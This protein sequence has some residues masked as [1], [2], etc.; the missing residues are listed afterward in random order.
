MA[1]WL[2]C[3]AT[4]SSQMVLDKIDGRNELWPKT[5]RRWLKMKKQK[6]YF[7]YLWSRLQNAGNFSWIS[8][9]IREKKFK[10]NQRRL[11]ITFFFCAERNPIHSTLTRNHSVEYFFLYTQFLASLKYTHTHTTT[12]R[13]WQKEKNVFLLKVGKKHSTV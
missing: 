1:A 2:I 12:T 4:L 11:A 9:K 10:H 7:K 8:D 5:V 3:G 6:K 13:K